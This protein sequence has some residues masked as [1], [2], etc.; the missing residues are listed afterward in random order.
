MSLKLFNTLSKSKEIFHPIDNSA[1]KVY[2]CGPT[3]YNNPHIGNF[4]PIIIFDILFR[5][6]RHI[7]GEDNV[8]YVRNITDIDDK[9]IT[10][11]NDL[12][13]STPDL[14][15]KTQAVYQKNL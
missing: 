7:Y 4:R 6:L 11:A 3:L 14:V 10:K 12:G 5:L 8:I 1:I 2:A 13:I 15:N 9:I